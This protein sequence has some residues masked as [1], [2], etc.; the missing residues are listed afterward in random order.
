MAAAW[1]PTASKATHGDELAGQQ[2][3]PNKKPS[4]SEGGRPAPL[5]PG[6][7]PGDEPYMM[8][9]MPTERLAALWIGM[10]WRIAFLIAEKMRAEMNRGEVGPDGGYPL[11]EVTSDE[12]QKRAEVDERAVQKIVKD[13]ITNGHLERVTPGNSLDGKYRLSFKK[14]EAARAAAAAARMARSETLKLC[15]RQRQEAPKLIVLHGIGPGHQRTITLDQAVESVRLKNVDAPEFSTAYLGR[16]A[17]G[18]GTFEIRLTPTPEKPPPGDFGEHVFARS[19]G[20]EAQAVETTENHPEPG[21]TAAHVASVIQPQ[22][23][24]LFG[25][26]L[27][28]RQIGEVRTLLTGERALEI[29]ALH[30]AKKPKGNHSPGILFGPKGMIAVA[31]AAA[32]AEAAL[33]KER[34][35]EPLPAVLQHGTPEWKAAQDEF[36]RTYK[37]SVEEDD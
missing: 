15:K 11:V 13:A 1:Q 30:M 37:P 17:D 4:Q 24:R 20:A 16:D 8:I 21:L 36:F 31:N 3:A 34:E 5:I 10:G 22:A 7:E 35:P 33:P 23:Q 26:A 6:W 19:D 28:A 25:H 9:P 27:T 18:C 29:L 2:T 14:L 32:A 12:M